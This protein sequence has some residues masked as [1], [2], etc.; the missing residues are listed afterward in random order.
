MKEV[1]PFSD[2]REVEAMVVSASRPS[3][4]DRSGIDGMDVV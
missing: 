3:W 1:E 2:V 4:G